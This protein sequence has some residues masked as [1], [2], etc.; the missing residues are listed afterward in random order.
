MREWFFFL[1]YFL[2]VIINYS[3]CQDNQ[4]IQINNKNILSYDPTN[5]NYNDSYSLIPI[6]DN[7]NYSSNN[8]CVT[9]PDLIEYNY[10]DLFENW[11]NWM[12][13]YPENFCYSM[14]TYNISRNDFY[15]IV[16]KNK[17]T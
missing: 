9:Y 5:Y 1:T 10:T 11:A 4:T 8:T 3:I 17:R 16:E 6:P 14:L 15:N 2:S 13:V 12:H 7:I